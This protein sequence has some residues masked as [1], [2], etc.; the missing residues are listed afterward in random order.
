MQKI[1]PS[2]LTVTGLLLTPYMS[3]AS[4]D[5]A[6]SRIINGNTS[7]KN[8][9]PFMAAIV[10]KGSGSV[11]DR[12]I[13]GGTFLGG[14]YVLTAEHCVVDENSGK[15]TSASKLQVAV[16]VYDLSSSS[17]QKNWSMYRRSISIQSMMGIPVIWRF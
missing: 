4:A 16:G 2:L 10:T 11:Y 8:Q 7:A 5:F 3:H 1:I 12:Q 14:R 9:W 15:K 6:G 13:C 17:A